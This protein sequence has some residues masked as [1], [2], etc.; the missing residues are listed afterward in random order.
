[1]N[2]TPSNL[3]LLLE[4]LKIIKPTRGTKVKAGIFVKIARPRNIPESKS[5]TILGEES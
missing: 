4:F 1:M 2:H 3:K 5:I